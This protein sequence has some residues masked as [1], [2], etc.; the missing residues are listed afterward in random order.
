MREMKDSGV[1]WIGE[2]PINWNISK[3]KYH[4][5]IGSGTTPKSDDSN[6]WDGNI[7]WITPA[8]FKT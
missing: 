8:D 5:K 7:V 4:F 2:I 6:L 1:E 3:L